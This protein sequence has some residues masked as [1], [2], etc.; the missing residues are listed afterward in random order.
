MHGGR[1]FGSPFLLVCVEAQKLSSNWMSASPAF[2]LCQFHSQLGANLYGL[3]GHYE[4]VLE[5][6]SSYIFL[7][8]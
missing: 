3:S 6:V 8:T 1:L 4:G 5:Y 2:G 7:G